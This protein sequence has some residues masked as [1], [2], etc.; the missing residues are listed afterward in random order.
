[1]VRC[2]L[3]RSPN[4]TAT[5]EK[6]PMTELT[7]Q[8]EIRPLIAALETKRQ[9]LLGRVKRVDSHLASQASPEGRVEDAG[10]LHQNDEVLEHLSATDRTELDL[11]AAALHCAADGVYGACVD[12]HEDIA[13]ERLSAI[14]WAQR[15]IACE[16]AHEKALNAR[17]Q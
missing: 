1:M 3:R 7:R 10:S 16:K 15:C 11:L 13:L 4:P 17:P 8:E 2:L 5:P 14:P 6:R 12:C 9:L